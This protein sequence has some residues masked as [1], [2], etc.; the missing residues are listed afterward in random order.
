MLWDC[1]MTSLS[2]KSTFKRFSG[3]ITV[4]PRWHHCQFSFQ[5]LFSFL[6]WQDL[7]FSRLASNSLCSQE[8]PWTYLP[9]S[10]LQNTGITGV[11]HHA[12]FIQYWGRTPWPHTCSA[13][14]LPTLYPQP[15]FQELKLKAS[16]RVPHLQA[17]MLNGACMS[18]WLKTETNRASHCPVPVC[19]LAVYC[20][21]HMC[22]LCSITELRWGAKV[23]MEWSGVCRAGGN[24]Q[25]SWF[26]WDP[27]ICAPRRPVLSCTEL[28][29]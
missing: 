18:T 26:E 21:V 20:V 4:T 22:S 17:N 5:C 10:S 29:F 27:N 15:R 11:H 1:R 9:T 24:R 7:M 19:S 23:W 2:T 14:T 13:S 25:F 8:W 6:S 28:R 16:W 3:I 12:P